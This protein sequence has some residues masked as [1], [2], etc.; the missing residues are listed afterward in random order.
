MFT[1][2]SVY[3]HDP[4]YE[5][6]ILANINKLPVE[7][8]EFVSSFIPTKVKMFL[9]KDLYLENH[10]FIKNYINTTRFDTYIRDI[11]RK[12]HAFIFQNLLVHNVNK[13]IKWRH[14]LF[15]D[16]IYM[17]F[18]IFL[19]FYCIDNSSSKCRKLIQEKIKELGLSKNQHKK[20]LIKYI[21]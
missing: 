4:N 13:W 9:N 7:L 10:R 20:N 11:I 3:K 14:Y 12:D 1:I 2:T 16:C 21:Q 6:T 15:R 8:K 18:L 5:L 19:N 17:N